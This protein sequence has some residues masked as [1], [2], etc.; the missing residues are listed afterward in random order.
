MKENK[1]RQSYA[2]IDRKKVTLGRASYQAQTNCAK[3]WVWRGS[4]GEE[5][6]TIHKLWGNI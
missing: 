4:Q 2:N 5:P 6:G 1:V 3:Q